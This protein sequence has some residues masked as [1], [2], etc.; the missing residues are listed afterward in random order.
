MKALKCNQKNCEI[1]AIVKYTWP[2]RDQAGSCINHMARIQ[3]VA[4]AMGLHIQFLPL[5]KEEQDALLNTVLK[6]KI[7]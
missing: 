7:E 3:G 5:D 4:E 1:E 2:G 6:E